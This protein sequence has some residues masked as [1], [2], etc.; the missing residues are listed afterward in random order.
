[1]KG[2]KK[3]PSVTLII[4]TNITFHSSSS[5]FPPVNL[6]Y[7]LF[8]SH[9]DPAIDFSDMKICNCVLI[10]ENKWLLWTNTSGKSA[11]LIDMTVSMSLIF[12]FIFCFLLFFLSGELMHVQFPPIPNPPP[13]FFVCVRARAEMRPVCLLLSQIAPMRDPKITTKGP[14]W[15]GWKPCHQPFQRR[16]SPPLLYLWVTPHTSHGDRKGRQSH[17]FD[18]NKYFSVLTGL[19][20]P[21]FPFPPHP[22]TAPL[23]CSSVARRVGGVPI[24]V[25]AVW[26]RIHG[27]GRIKKLGSSWTIMDTMQ[28]KKERIQHLEQT[29]WAHFLCP[30]KVQWEE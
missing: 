30:Q 24:V 18:R 17:I 20:W 7:F 2:W 16:E 4:F 9:S 3:V 13:P 23:L 5:F 8:G 14:Q 27:R 15:V 12:F 6:F 28:F 19:F 1:M 21:F 22:P 25:W 11:S 26:S 29:E 10:N